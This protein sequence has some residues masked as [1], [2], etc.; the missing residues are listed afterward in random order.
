M[1]KT[2][3]MREAHK[4]AKGFEGNYSACLAL[5]LRTLNRKEE[6]TEMKKTITIN[7]LETIL[8]DTGYKVRKSN[9]EKYAYKCYSKSNLK[10][11]VST[12]GGVLKMT[13]NTPYF[14]ELKELNG[15]VIV[16]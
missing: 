13:I 1:T 14:N 2:N 15:L 10:I 3:M 12:L 4:M 7:E 11:T 9:N 8:E 16:Y 6:A 5:A